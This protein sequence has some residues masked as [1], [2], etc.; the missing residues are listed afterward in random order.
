MAS[1]VAALLG[2]G[3]GM[4]M[5]LVLSLARLKTAPEAEPPTSCPLALKSL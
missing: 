2:G 1:R 5:E 4:E 3:L